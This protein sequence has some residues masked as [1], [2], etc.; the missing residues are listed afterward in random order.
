MPEELNGLN[1]LVLVPNE[2]FPR[3]CGHDKTS[4]TWSFT[5]GFFMVYIKHRIMR[6]PTKFGSNQFYYN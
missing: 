1:D 3:R 2:E 6:G 5:I 4:T